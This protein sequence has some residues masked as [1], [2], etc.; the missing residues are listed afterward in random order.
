VGDLPFATSR[1]S[2][3]ALVQL[4]PRGL[5]VTAA[6]LLLER[7]AGSDAPARHLVQETEERPEGT[8]SARPA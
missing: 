7:I 5:G 8:P 6:G 2:D 3:V 4:N 1:T